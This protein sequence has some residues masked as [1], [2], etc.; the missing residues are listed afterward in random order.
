V[1]FASLDWAQDLEKNTRYACHLEF[2]WW[3]SRKKG[4][5]WTTAKYNFTVGVGVGGSTIEVAWE[6]TWEKRLTRLGVNL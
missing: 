3:A 1:C 2:I 4:G 6:K 5:T